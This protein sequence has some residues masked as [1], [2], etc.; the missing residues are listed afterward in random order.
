MG[1][2]KKRI[3]IVNDDQ[4]FIEVYEKAFVQAGFEVG[5]AMDG[6]SG[7]T[8]ILTTKPDIVLLGLMLPIMNGFDVLKVL[9]ERET[10]KDLPVLICSHLVAPGSP[11]ESE[12]KNMGATKIFYKGAC[13]P[14][15]V[16][17][18]A[19]DALGK[20]LT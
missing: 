2:D 14:E 3:F 7:L 17:K 10:T 13:T 4:T 11:E 5:S 12:A 1:R 19:H 6:K 15:M 8:R 18:A 9:R 16:I 20:D